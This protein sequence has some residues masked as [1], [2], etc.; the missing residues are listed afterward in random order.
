M[1]LAEVAACSRAVAESSGRLRKIELLASLLTRV[2][3]EEIEVAVAFLSGSIRQGRVGIGRSAL[4]GARAVPAA[5]AASVELPDVDAQFQ[6]V[7]AAS[8]PGSAQNRAE[9]LRDLF[10]RA[11]DEEQ[12]FLA[13]LLLFSLFDPVQRT[14]IAEDRR[15]LN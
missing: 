12:R 8:G 13:G 14:P 1:R 15:Y 7:A 10:R 3:P 4:S 5:G 6:R 2:P 11:T 9:I